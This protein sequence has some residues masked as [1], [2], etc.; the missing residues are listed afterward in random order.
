MLFPNLI[1]INQ[2]DYFTNRYKCFTFWMPLSV[3]WD[4]TIKIKLR[5]TTAKTE[6]FVVLMLD[7]W[8]RKNKNSESENYYLP[9]K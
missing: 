3:F 8:I 4:V 2:L 6:T 9:D 1:I 5:L 7:E